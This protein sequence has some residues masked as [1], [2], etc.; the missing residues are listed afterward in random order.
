METVVTDFELLDAWAAGDPLAGERLFKR[1]LRA[2]YRFFR[3]KLDDGIDDRVQDTLV[4][5]VRARATFRRDAEFRTF[6]LATA[7]NVLFKEYRRRRRS[8]V[9]VDFSVHAVADLAPGPST[10]LASVDEHRILLDALRA[11][12]IDAQ[13][14]LELHYLERLTGPQLAQALEITEPAV[15]SRLRRAKEALRD[16]LGALER[17]P[18]SLVA[19]DGLEDWAAPLRDLIERS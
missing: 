4:A 1:H 7:R 12:P 6:L 9:A 15:R 13:I 14:V 5:C 3:T 18:S 17:C 2:L 10:I 8:G 19:L 16:R 11:L